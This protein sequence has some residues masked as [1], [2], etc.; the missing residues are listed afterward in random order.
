MGQ[1]SVL[2]FAR[3][4]KPL[5]AGALGLSFPAFVPSIVLA[6]QNFGSAASDSALPDAPQPQQNREASTSK[7]SGTG[8]ITGTVLDSTGDVVQ[9]ARVTC[10]RLP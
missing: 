4:S 6:Q 8:T 7:Q 9:G 10:T 1:C 2:K 5:L 3:W